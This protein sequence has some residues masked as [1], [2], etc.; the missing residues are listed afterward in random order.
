VIQLALGI[1]VFFGTQQ[2]QIDISAAGPQGWEQRVYH[3]KENVI[4]T[5][6]DM[7]IEADEVTYDDDTKIVTAGDHVN[8]TRGDEILNAT[9]IRLNVET[10]VGDFS[11]VSGKMGPGFYVIAQEAHRTEEGQY[12]L[13][14]AV[15]TTCEGPSPGWSMR[16]ARAVVDPDKRT[17]AKGSVFR[18]ESVPFFYMPYLT[19]PS[20]NRTRATGFL[21][22]S[23]STSTTKGRSLR[24]TF[25]WA[26][27]RSADVAFTG[28]YFSARGPAGEINFRAVPEANSRINIYSMFAHDRL[29]QGGEDLRILAFGELGRGF[30]GGANMDLVSSFVFRQVYENG[31]N[32]ITSPIQQSAAFATRNSPDTSINFLYSRN[33]VFFTNEPTAVLRKFPSFELSVPERTVSGLPLYFNVGTNVSS[34]SRRDAS[35]TSPGFVNRL[36]LHPALEIPVVRSSMLDWDQRVGFRETFYA[37]SREPQTVVSNPLNRLSFDYTSNLT[38]PQLERDFGSWRHVIEPSVNYYYVNGANRYRN[39]IVVDNIDLFTNRSDVEYA[40]TN[41]IFTNREVFSWRLAQRYFLD[42]TFGGAIVPGQRNAITPILDVSGFDFEDGIRRFSPIISRMRFST[43]PS[44][45][46]DVQMDYDTRDHLFRSAGIIGNAS[47]GFFVGGVSYFFTRASTVEIPSNQLRGS[48]TYGNRLKPGF[49]AALSVSYDVLHSVFQGSTT[50]VGYN[51]SCYGLSLELN[52]FNIGPRI[53]TRFVFSFSLKNVG[54][55]GTLRPA[56]RLF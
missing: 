40:I 55:V 13:K 47:R 25:Y 35:I 37:D 19:V 30:R 5:Y 51:T 41:R 17:V 53:E 11:N 10:K 6:R 20:E 43:S 50:E 9:H 34:I 32:V 36:D 27:N 23:T 56:E 31:L 52:Q 7:R 18:L 26:I 16:T 54:S 42:P 28:E 44:T 33:G 38:G 29:G 8:F 45:S 12:Q 49:S 46:T 48:I 15:V 4:V 2:D 21:I 1:F 14:N 3:A 24:E 22:P 39:T